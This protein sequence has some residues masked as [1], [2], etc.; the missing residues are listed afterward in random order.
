[1][2]KQ[3]RIQKTSV[4]T[5]A[6]LDRFGGTVRNLRH[7]WEHLPEDIALEEREM[8]IEL[9]SKVLTLHNKIREQDKNNS[10]LN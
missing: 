8:F 1:M 3:D 9:T 10:N 2:R 6:D 7:A 4:I 5:T